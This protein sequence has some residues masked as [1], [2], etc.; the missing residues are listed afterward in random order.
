ML[1][2]VYKRDNRIYILLD[3]VKKSEL[4]NVLNVGVFG[5]NIN[6][7]EYCSV[8]HRWNIIQKGIVV[9][10]TN[11]KNFEEL[12]EKEKELFQKEWKEADN[13]RRAIV[14][15]LFD[16]R[17]NKRFPPNPKTTTVK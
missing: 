16:K 3:E 17:R 12:D 6:N 9:T 13:L 14:V 11:T 2:N 8:Y 7:E 15:Y 10:S 4:Q 5:I 1:D